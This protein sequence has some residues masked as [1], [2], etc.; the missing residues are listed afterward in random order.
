MKTPTIPI[1]VDGKTVTVNVYS[2]KGRGL[3]APGGSR[4][5]VIL[6]VTPR[7]FTFTEPEHHR[8][9][10]QTCY[11]RSLADHILITPAYERQ[12]AAELARREQESRAQEAAL[13]MARSACTLERAIRAAEPQVDATSPEF[14]AWSDAM[15]KWA[16]ND[17]EGPAPEQPTLPMLPLRFNERES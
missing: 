6:R 14:K 7:G 11:H 9:F 16:V 3:K 4:T 5:R 13:M 10:E 15:Q 2:L 17:C 8:Y 12:R 1:I